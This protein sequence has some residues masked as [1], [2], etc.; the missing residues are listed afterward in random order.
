MSGDKEHCV[1]KRIIEESLA[2]LS[3]AGRREYEKARLHLIDII[4]VASAGFKL[5]PKPPII[6]RSICSG[7]GPS[8][9]FGL[10]RKTSPLQAAVINSFSAHVLELDDWLPEGFIHPGA[11]IVPSVLAVCESLNCTLEDVL[12]ALILGYEVAGR[13]GMFLGRKHYRRWHT[14]STAGGVASAVAISY[15]RGLSTCDIIKAA[16]T[17]VAYSSGIWCIIGKEVAVKPM[18]PMHA[19]FLGM[20]SPLLTS[21]V[22]SS[23]DKTLDPSNHVCNIVSA[24]CNLE[25]ITPNWD[26]AIN[27]AGFKLFPACRNSHT[28]IQAAINLHGKADPLKISRIVIEVFE[29]AFQVADI[30][31]PLTVEEAKFS[32]SYLASIGISRGWVGLS[33]L[34]E[35]LRDPVV[36]KLEGLVEIK[37][38]EDFTE[39]YP[40]KQPARVIVYLNDGEKL[41]SYEE[42]PLG[43]INHPLSE[44]KLMQKVRMLSR[45][46]RDPK[47]W[48]I[49]KALRN[50]LLN[51]RINEIFDF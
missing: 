32:L 45:D 29:E 41:E 44:E 42:V 13:I 18:S 23:L 20:I 26:F 22:V 37:V 4:A 1:L 38:R 48:E 28:V 17:A 7:D 10:W 36:R 5:D 16:A 49:I 8:T 11:S 33:E 51:T 30:K 35:G 25:S 12:E 43:D 24:E 14:T 40:I 31:F 47:L 2:T 34:K 19:A 39:E 3:R 27:K 21:Y 46:S 50:A 9:I 6:Y 15:L